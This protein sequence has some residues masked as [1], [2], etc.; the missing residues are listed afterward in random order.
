MVV[1]KNVYIP[2]SYHTPMARHLSTD[3]I[4][5]ALYWDFPGGSVV[6]NQQE[7]WVRSLVQEDPTC[8]AAAKAMHPQLLSLCSWARE[9]KLLK[10]TCPRAHEPQQEKPVQ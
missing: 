1:W 8:L 5:K 9:P 2:L 4:N 3:C 10:P 7:T 6:K